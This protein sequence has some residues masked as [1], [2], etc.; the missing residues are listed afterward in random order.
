LYRISF[1]LLLFLTLLPVYGCSDDVE[2]P[3]QKPQIIGDSLLIDAS[4]I[5]YR[6]RRMGTQLWMMENM[7]S[8][9]K[10]NPIYT[11]DYIEPPRDSSGNPRGL[12]YNY[13]TADVMAPVGWRLPTLSDIDSLLN[14]LGATKEDAG[15]YIKGGNGWRS[16]KPNGVFALPAAG[17]AYKIMTGFSDYKFVNSDSIAYLWLAEYDK[18]GGKNLLFRASSAEMEVEDKVERVET[19]MSVRYVTDSPL[20]LPLPEDTIDEQF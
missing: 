16:P 5:K 15:N 2:A 20:P 8:V 9:R 13:F 7:R 4:N 12:L 3:E 18:F 17:Y 6:I 11:Y 19:Y 10:A 1:I 14:Y